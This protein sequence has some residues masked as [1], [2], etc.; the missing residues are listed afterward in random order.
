MAFSKRLTVL[1]SLVKNKANVYDVGADHGQLEILLSSRV[2]KIIAVENKK[3]P[4]QN[5]LSATHELKN[6]HCYLGN[7]LDYLDEETNFLILA[8]LGSKT[9]IEIIDENLD[10]IKRL[11][12][13]L[14]DSHTDLR[15]LREYFV[16][17]RFYLDQEII[18][19]EKGIFYHLIRFKRGQ[20]NY[21]MLELEFG[22]IKNDPLKKE[23]YN[24]L[25]AKTLKIIAKK[26]EAHM[27]TSLEIAYL[28][29]M[30]KYYEIDE[31]HA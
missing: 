12:Y 25:K 2:K 11:E 13:L 5:L 23:E 15:I 28:E 8:G 3:G 21:S 17:H 22:L 1:A 31:N 29:R 24:F 27:D 4:Y 10:K 16:S 6:V 19:S 18:V 7:G 14:I 30:K 9:I 20:R 26:I